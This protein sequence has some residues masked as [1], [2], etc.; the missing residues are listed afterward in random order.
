MPAS[1]SA[2]P[3]SDEPQ[4]AQTEHRVPSDQDQ[5]Q[6]EVCRLE[7]LLQYIKRDINKL[8][9]L[10]M[11]NHK[12]YDSMTEGYWAPA[13]EQRGRISRCLKFEYSARGNPKDSTNMTNTSMGVSWI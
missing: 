9:L 7:V 13:I 5:N 1:W 12:G 10:Q 6:K 3:A 2:G 4:K 11:T 8:I